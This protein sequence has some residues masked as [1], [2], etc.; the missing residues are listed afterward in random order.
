MQIAPRAHQQLERLPAELSER[1]EQGLGDLA[2][3]A[4]CQMVRM[5]LCRGLETA[6]GS[7]IELNVAEGCVASLRINDSGRTITLVEVATRC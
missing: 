2:E 1:I 5:T 7:L 4:D 6:G 3:V